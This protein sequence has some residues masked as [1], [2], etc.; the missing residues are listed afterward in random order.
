MPQPDAGQVRALVRQLDDQRFPIRQ[1]ADRR[2]RELGIGA[3]PLLRQE[4]ARR[5]ALEVYRRL[6][7]IVEELARIEWRHDLKE[8]LEEAKRTGKPLL[9]LSSLGRSNGTGSLAT[10]AMAARTLS[11][12]KLI[13]FISQHYVPV[14]HQQLDDAS[15]EFDL[16]PGLQDADSNYTP[17]QIGQ[18]EEGR[19][20]RNLRTFFCT[21]EG[22]VFR[23]LEG[24]A[25]AAPY[26]A[27]VQE[28]RQ[29]LGEARSAPA[30]Q[31][32]ELLR[33]ILSLRGE[34]LTRQ[35]QGLAGQEAALADLHAR[36]LM[37]SATLVDQPIES[38][39]ERVIR[40]NH[41][42]G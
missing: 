37:A 19:G 22:T 1:E 2:L 29:L 34:E 5:P 40:D 31:R 10:Q 18:Y 33:T 4:L 17:E 12:L 15:L 36:L 14:W 35:R 41:F 38:I 32:S 42:F 21:P 23:C 13:H 25:S 7:A 6:E 26:L 30:G 9:V 11:D 8:A 20:V 28:A 3:V 39:L 16:F 24:F 27:Q